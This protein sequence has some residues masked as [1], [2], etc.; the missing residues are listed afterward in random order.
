MMF[1]KGLIN[2]VIVSRAGGSQFSHI[3]NIVAHYILMYGFRKPRPYFMKAI[4]EG[5]VSPT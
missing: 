2:V 4:E 3:Y 1:M 5:L